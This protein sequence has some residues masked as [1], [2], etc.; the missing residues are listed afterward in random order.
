[1]RAGIRVLSANPANE[2]SRRKSAAYDIIGRPGTPWAPLFE[3]LATNVA[4]APPVRPRPLS[5]DDLLGLF[6]GPAVGRDVVP[7][8]ATVTDMMGR[9]LITK[10]SLDVVH[11]HAP[12]PPSPIH[13]CPLQPTDPVSSIGW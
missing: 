12:R 7:Q 4:E 3:T 1:M 11:A 5:Q 9:E 13:L 8:P 10:P 6:S 2:D